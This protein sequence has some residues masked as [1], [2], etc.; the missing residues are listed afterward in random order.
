[1]HA[2]NMAYARMVDTDTYVYYFDRKLPGDD[3]GSF[4][5]AE[6]WYV[7]GSLQYCWRPLDEAD[8]DLS[9]RMITYWSNFMKC[10]NPNGGRDSEWRPCT[11]S[12]PY[13]EILK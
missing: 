3:A 8:Y 12:D 4:H 7:F 10:G 11:E 6:L 13:F 9:R 5:S 1:M 2:A